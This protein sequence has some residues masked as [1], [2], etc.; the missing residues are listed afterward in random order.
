M[1]APVTVVTTLLDG[2]PYGTTVSAFSSLSMDPPLVLVSLDNTSDLLAAV[3]QTRRMGINVLQKDQCQL[4]LN[5]ARKG[6]SKF[7]DVGWSDAQA[8]P[9]LLDVKAFMCCEVVDIVAGGDHSILLGAVEAGEVLPGEPL[10]YFE[11]SF[12]THLATAV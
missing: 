4:A 8:S 3:R 12:G 9:R 7:A 6:E 2:R 11:R 1:A 10:T 5:F